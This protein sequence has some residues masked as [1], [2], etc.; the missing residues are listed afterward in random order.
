MSE[1]KSVFQSIFNSLFGN[2]GVTAKSNKRKNSNRTCRIEELEGREMLSVTPWSL[3]DNVFALNNEM[4]GGH[5]PAGEFQTYTPETGGFTPAALAQNTLAPLAG[6]TAS[7]QAWLDNF[8]ADHSSLAVTVA[9]WAGDMITRLDL[10][11]M[12]LTGTLDVTGMTPQEQAVWTKEVEK[13][14]KKVSVLEKNIAALE[15]TLA[16]KI[17]A[18]E[19]KV[20]RL[21]NKIERLEEKEKV[22]EKKLDKLE[23]QL[24]R[25]EEK[26]ERRTDKLEE[27]Y[28]AK[29]AQQAAK[30]DWLEEAAD[31]I[32]ACDSAAKAKAMTKVMAKVVAQH[33]KI[34][35]QETKKEKEENKDSPSP[36]T[37]DRLEEA[38]D[39]ANAR[40]DRL[41]EDA[42]AIA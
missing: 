28:A 19:R 42:N 26:V 37:L 33:G 10:S 14:Q 15:K 31:R 40:L 35:A 6:D 8:L 21:E 22:S 5:T 38:L 2:T 30:L 20:E 16:K 23:R 25:L 4:S 29:I 34:Y 36:K 39:K 11:D 17:R 41:Y 9:T 1:S 12:G 32:A 7:D 13:A 27:Q 24:E 3:A 18:E